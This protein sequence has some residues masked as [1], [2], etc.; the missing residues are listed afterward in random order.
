MYLEEGT[1]TIAAVVFNCCLAMTIYFQARDI[2]KRCCKEDPNKRPTAADV[3]DFFK[4]CMP[5]DDE[6]PHKFF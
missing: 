6:N 5:K 3:K 1:N 4:R 2:G